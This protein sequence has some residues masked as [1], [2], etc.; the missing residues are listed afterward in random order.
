MIY[1]IHLHKPTDFRTFS[2]ILVIKL[3]DI[4]LLVLTPFNIL[5]IFTCIFFIERLMLNTLICERHLQYHKKWRIILSQLFFT[6]VQNVYST[7]KLQLIPH[8]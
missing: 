6:N 4:S 8:M 2:S 1:Y 7:L 3:I 5:S